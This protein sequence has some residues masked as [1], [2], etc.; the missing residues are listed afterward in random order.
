MKNLTYIFSIIFIISALSIA[1]C[2]SESDDPAPTDT[3]LR[4]AELQNNGLS[5]VVLNGGV[6]KDGFDVSDQF[7]GFKLTIGEFTFTTENS[8]SGAWPTSGTWEFVNENPNQILRSD[9][10]QMIVDY[11]ASGLTLTFTGSGSSGGRIESVDGEYQF[12][13]VSE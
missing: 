13:L 11:S 5:W 2:K 1:G 9:G 10:I 4:L 6:T 3:E 7:S 8:L 12:R